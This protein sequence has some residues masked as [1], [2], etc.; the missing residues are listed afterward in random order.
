VFFNDPSGA[1]KYE[2]YGLA[3]YNRP[4]ARQLFFQS[5]V[6][7]T[8]YETISDVTQ[9]SNSELP[10][11]RSDVAEYRKGGD[12][13]LT[14]LL[15][16]RFY[17][18]EARVYGRLSAG[19]YEEMFSGFGGQALYL[20]RGGGWSADVAADWVRQRDF[21]GWFGHQDYDTITAIASLNYRMAHGGDRH[22]ARRTLPG[23]GRGRAR[24]GEA[25][26][27]LR[28]RGRRLVYLHQRQRHHLARHAVEPVLRQGH[29]HGD[30]PRHAAHL[31]HAGGRRLRAR[32]VDA[33]RRPDGGLAG[34]PCAHRRA[35]D[36]ADAQPRR[37]RAL[38]ATATTITTCR[39]S[40]RWR[41]TTPCSAAPTS[42]RT[43]TG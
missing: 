10:H 30:A 24:G 20:G 8:L 18:P 5:D 2:L 9:P 40:A 15:L 35:A 14:R 3:S 43:R 42:T 34:R 4:L 13:K 1:F 7:L 17:H 31:R 21:E 11:V 33:R 25:P 37:P 36:G 12:F 41:S 32:A 6:K 22:R 23:E 27:R 29:L 38:S 19:I 28:L 16:N 39:C 26:L